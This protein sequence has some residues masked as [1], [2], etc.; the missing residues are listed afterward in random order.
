MTVRRT[1]RTV[2][3]DDALVATGV[4][5]DDLGATGDCVSELATDGPAAMMVV[6]SSAPVRPWARTFLS[7]T[8]RHLLRDHRLRG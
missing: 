4:A 5:V 8:G 3:E 7:L 6:L 1:L 2:N